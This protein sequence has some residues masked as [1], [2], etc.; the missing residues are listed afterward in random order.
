MIQSHKAIIRKENTVVPLL[1]S[2]EGCQNYRDYACF[3]SPGATTRQE[4]TLVHYL[5]DPPYNQYFEKGKYG[6]SLQ[7]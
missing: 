7:L 2:R 6:K 5:A 1:G 3:S 4:S